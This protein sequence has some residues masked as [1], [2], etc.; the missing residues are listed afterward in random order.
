MNLSDEHRKSFDLIRRNCEFDSN[1]IDKSD[2]QSEKHEEPRS[3]TWHRIKIEL[4]FDDKN[5]NDSICDESD[6]ELAKHCESRISTLR[7]IK[8][9]FSDE[10]EKLLI[11]F[12]P[13][14]NII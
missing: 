5:T 9:D 11:Q 12:V 3:E 6:A 13:I 8:I 10:N 1:S 14:L 7:G 2:L 4:S